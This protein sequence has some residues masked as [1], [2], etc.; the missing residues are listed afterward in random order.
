MTDILVHSPGAVEEPSERLKGD[1]DDT[2]T[3]MPR[4]RPDTHKK[5]RHSILCMAGLWGYKQGPDGMWDRLP[6]DPLTVPGAQ[7]SY[8]GT[9]YVRPVNRGVHLT[10]AAHYEYLEDLP[11]GDYDVRLVFVRRDSEDET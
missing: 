11:S 9:A 2:G 7:W 8:T 6:R 4:C 5:G 3:A 1:V 10:D